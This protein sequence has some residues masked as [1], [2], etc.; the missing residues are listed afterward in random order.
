MKR[1]V[2]CL[3]KC[4]GVLGFVVAGAGATAVRAAGANEVRY[5]THIKAV[6]EARCIGCHGGDAPE[7]GDFKKD[8][9]KFTAAS[10]GPRMDT[11]PHLI[12]YAGWPDTGAL[13]RR[14]DDGSGAKDGKPGNMYRHL[15]V[16]DAERQKN[17]KLL[18]EW[19]GN[20]THKR[21]PEL[22]KEDLTGIAVPY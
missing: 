11:Y 15:G 22:T 19:V 18:K 1:S 13:M 7:Y 9:E 6:V 14:L 12:F 16:D 3:A 8:K 4:L 17:L 20:W 10:R 5:T 21:F 2:I